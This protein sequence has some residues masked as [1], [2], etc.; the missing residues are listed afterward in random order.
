[1]FEL[2]FQKISSGLTIAEVCLL[3]RYYCGY[4]IASDLFTSNSN[5]ASHL[6]SVT[7]PKYHLE[8]AI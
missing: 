4:Q 1:M 5:Q 8:N 3:I 2:T 7:P 6:Q